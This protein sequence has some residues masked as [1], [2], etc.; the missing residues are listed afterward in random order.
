MI[1]FRENSEDIYCGIEFQA[2]SEESKKIV[3][4]LKEDFGIDKIR[5]P[6]TVGIGVK[7]ISKEGH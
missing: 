5:F 7:P 4:I 6:D 1:I 2:G 3:K